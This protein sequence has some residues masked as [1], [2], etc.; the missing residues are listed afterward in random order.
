MPTYVHN[1]NLIIRK[2][3]VA[4]KYVGGN[5]QFRKDYSI[6]TSEVNQEDDELFCLGSMNVEDF[7]LDKLTEKGLN[8]DAEKQFSADFTILYRSGKCSWA[9]DWLI[10]DT[11][12]AWD[13]LTSETC[14]EKANRISS[15]N[16]DQIR[17]MFENGE[18]PF[19][20]IRKNDLLYFRYN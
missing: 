20:T 2:S 7:D 18:N 19:A 4:E 8:F 1:C 14:L 11:I 17:A 16:M 12:F 5:R 6:G 15:M 3:V 10:N 9:T 13:I